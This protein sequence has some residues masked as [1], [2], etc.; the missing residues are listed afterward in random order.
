MADD[1][2]S[3]KAAHNGKGFKHGY[4]YA[5]WYSS[6]KSMMQRCYLLTHAKY[7]DYGAKGIV[8]CKEWHDINNFAKWVEQSD[9]KPCLTI[10]RLNSKGDYTPENCRWATKRQQS[11]NRYN[12]FFC[13]YKG[14]T[15]ALTDWAEIL[16]INPYTLYSRI[17]KSGWSIQKAF[18]TP[19]KHSRGERREEN[20]AD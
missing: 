13:E 4:Y 11:N 16:G 5:P 12:T 1:L 6:Y 14:V 10:D 20:A 9:Y 2:I 3:R 18:E 17:K 8:V 19:V 15:K 7:K